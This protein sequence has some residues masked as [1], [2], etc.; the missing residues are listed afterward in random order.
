MSI[1]IYKKI[2]LCGLTNHAIEFRH[3]LKE[4]W[5]EEKQ[6]IVEV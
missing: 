4:G 5:D 2:V 6:K 3:L 1:K